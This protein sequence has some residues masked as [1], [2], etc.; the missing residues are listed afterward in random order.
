M[1]AAAIAGLILLLSGAANAAGI[2]PN[3]KLPTDGDDYSALVARAAAHDESV[4]FRALRVAYL[5]SAARRRAGAAYDAMKQLN[6]D[7]GAALKAEDAPVIR[8]KAEQILSLDFTDMWAHKLLRQSCAILH[9]DA[10]ADL[11]HFLEFGLLRSITGTGDGK[12]CATGWEATQVKEEYVM[13]AMLGLRFTQQ[14]LISDGGHACDAMSVVDENGA[15]QTYY[16]NIDVMMADEA[17]AL[18]PK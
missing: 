15:A 14:A 4:D 9:D 5:K 17:A 11:H 18:T 1:R 13:L 12:T 10:C 2:S 7:L 8:D 16:F 6:A 3:I